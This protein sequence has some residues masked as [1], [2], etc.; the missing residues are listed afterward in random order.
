MVRTI[1]HSVNHKIRSHF[2]QEKSIES[3]VEGGGGRVGG[4][5]NGHVT[6]FWF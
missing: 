2:S 5:G 6:R 1:S 3:L 4:G